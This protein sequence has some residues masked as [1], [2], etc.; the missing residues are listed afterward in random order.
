MDLPVTATNPTLHQAV[1]SV[2]DAMLGAVAIEQGEARLTYGALAGQVRLLA[3][4]LRNAGVGAEDVVALELAP[5][6]RTVVAMLACGLCGAA[7]LPLKISWLDANGHWPRD[8]RSWI[9]NS[10][11]FTNGAISW[12]W[13]CGISQIGL[14]I[15]N[16]SSSGPP[17]R[18]YSKSKTFLCGR[19]GIFGVV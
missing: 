11:Y 16:V 2:A 7:F 9:P 15:Q 18:R 13:T 6:P 8:I 17:C 19:S 4:E 12:A 10:P 14:C 5:S 1:L 3:D